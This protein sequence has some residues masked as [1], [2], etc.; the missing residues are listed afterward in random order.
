[1]L[2]PSVVL[3][4]AGVAL[5]A[6]GTLQRYEAMRPCMGSLF[7][8][9]LYASSDDAAQRAFDAAF[10]RIEELNAI[11][12]DYDSESEAL[13][14][15]HGAPMDRPLP[16]SPEMWTVLERSIRLSQRTDGAFDVTV[17]PLTRLWRRARRRRELPSSDRLPQALA[18]VGH[19]HVRIDPK[20]HAVQLLVA[21]MRLDFG[22]IAKGYAADEAI[23]TMRKLNIQ[24]SLV[25]AGGDIAMGEPPPEQTGWRIGVA[26][27]EAD[28][29]PS[30]FLRLS[31]CGIATS[32]DAW[33]SVEIGGK[34]YS[35]IVDPRT[36]LGVVDRS[37]V[38]VVARDCM[39][40]D[41]LASAVSVL[42][43]DRGIELV[44]QTCGAS[45]LIVRVEEDQAK[46]HQSRRFPASE[47]KDVAP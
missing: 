8:I 46:T 30:R 14:L 39:T 11:F 18:A 28:D 32:G 7:E 43:P 41:S 6:D 23:R 24:R 37:S 17:G 3:A 34:R 16:V 12:S 1:L 47:S 45:C 38:T 33:Q 22:G 26:P 25:N 5:A 10:D 36:G 27:L 4:L 19:R 9:T 13:R 44:E 20:T 2:A 21:N 15:S 31:N 35:H 40:A 42:G 29:P